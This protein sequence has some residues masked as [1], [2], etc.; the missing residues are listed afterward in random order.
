MYGDSCRTPVKIMIAIMPS[1]PP[2]I[3][4]GS[5]FW[6]PDGGMSI[7][8]SSGGVTLISPGVSRGPRLMIGVNFLVVIRHL[9]RVAVPARPVLDPSSTLRGLG[10]AGSVSCSS[11]AACL[12]STG[13][14]TSRLTTC[15]GAVF[16][17]VRPRVP[18]V[19][20]SGSPYRTPCGSM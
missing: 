19:S 9:L 16:G 18:P 4:H 12:D 13:P 7:P 6:M 20:S 1:M 15:H 8:R 11:S 14:S 5:A 3:T 2:P 17:A 10:S